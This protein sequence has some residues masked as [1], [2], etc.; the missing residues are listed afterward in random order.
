MARTF[1]T[2]T[3][4]KLLTTF[5]RNRAMMFWGIIWPVLWV[6]IYAF[7]FKPPVDVPTVFYYGTA[8]AFL[9]QIAFSTLSI[10]G[11][12]EAAIDAIRMPYLF[13]FTKVNSRSYVGALLLSY[14]IFAIVQSVILV[15]ISPPLF[16]TGYVMVGEALPVIFLL[17]LTSALLYLELGIIVSYILLLLRLPRLAQIASFVP[18]ILMYISVLGQ[19]V[20]NFTGTAL[21]Y[22]PF[23]ELYTIT[24]LSLA[25]VAG[26]SYV[27]YTL[28]TYGISGSGLSYMVILLPLWLIGL[29]LVAVGLVTIYNRSGLRGKYKIEDLIGG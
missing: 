29:A 14:F 1:L 12:F 24:V 20:A 7:V 2:L 13:R 18:F 9:L 6:F 17:A 23:N 25:N 5:V 3:H 10:S 22:I 19:V 28:S 8:I 16:Q 4:I 15:V 11:A 26:P 27:S 21:V